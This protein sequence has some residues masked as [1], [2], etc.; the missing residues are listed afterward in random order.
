[1]LLRLSAFVQASRR[2]QRV[3]PCP[4]PGWASQLGR[5]SRNSVQHALDDEVGGEL[6]CPDT[7]GFTGIGNEDLLAAD[8][9]VEEGAVTVHHLLVDDELQAGL[10]EVV[11]A[12]QR[13]GVREELGTVRTRQELVLQPLRRVGGRRL[14]LL[15][16]QQ[17][18]SCSVPLNVVLFLE[19]IPYR[20]PDKQSITYV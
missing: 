18:L 4:H 14:A 5:P 8:G 19:E 6:A 7:G 12:R 2:A 9:A 16:T 20:C 17:V 13:L 3:P 11:H 10:A 1:M 15:L